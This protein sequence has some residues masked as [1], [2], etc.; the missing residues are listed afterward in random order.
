[1]EGIGKLHVVAHRDHGVAE[2]RCLSYLCLYCT[3]IYSGLAASQRFE[4][5][6]H[7]DALLAVSSSPRYQFGA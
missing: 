6:L 2:E 3:L 1:M 4:S 5:A 7:R